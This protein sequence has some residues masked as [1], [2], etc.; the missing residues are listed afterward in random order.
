MPRTPIY[1]F[2]H[3]GPNIMEDL[4]HP[5]ALKLATYGREITQTIR[6]KAVIVFSAHWQ[7]GPSNIEVNTAETLPLIYDYYGFPAH[8]YKFQ[9]PNVGNR[10]LAHDVLRRLQDAGIRA[11]GVER[12][13]DHGV[14]APFRVAFDPEKNP[15]NVP[16]VQVSLFDNEDAEMHIRLGKAVE[17]LRDEGV[18]IIVSGMAVHNLRDLRAGMMQGPGFYFPYAKTFSDALT[19]AVERQVCLVDHQGGLHANNL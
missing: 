7:A 13:L 19:D 6:P 2:S 14:F 12:G 1:F 11:Q 4:D 9:Y 8:Y 18:L 3:G 10:Q 5:A 15:L 17:G 16:I